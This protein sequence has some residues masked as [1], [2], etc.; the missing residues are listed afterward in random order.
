MLPFYLHQG[1][2]RRAEAAAP[3][4][5]R[6]IESPTWTDDARVEL[7]ALQTREPAAVAQMLFGSNYIFQARWRVF[8]FEGL[9]G[10]FVRSHFGAP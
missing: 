1:R 10:R 3:P 6:D 5:G 2:G 8:A 9:F 7:R 4:C